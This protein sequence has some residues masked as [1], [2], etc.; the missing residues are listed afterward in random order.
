[1]M[2]AQINQGLPRIIKLKFH[3][4]KLAS[5]LVTRDFSF[6]LFNDVSFAFVFFI[7]QV[8]WSFYL[9]KFRNVRPSHV[10]K[11]G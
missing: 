5:V 4:F 3:F 7:G 1:M 10:G 9:D 8:A 2:S 11:P 6:D